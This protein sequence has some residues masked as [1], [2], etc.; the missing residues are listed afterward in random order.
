MKHLF[1]FFAAI[2]LSNFLWAQKIDTT[3]S[4]QIGVSVYTTCDTQPQYPGGLDSLF[5]LIGTNLAYPSDAREFNIQGTVYIGFIVE[6]DGTVSN[7][8]IYKGIGAGC[9]EES[10]RVLSKMK[11]WEPGY[12]NGEAVYTVCYIPI[13]FVLQGSSFRGSKK[14][15]SKNK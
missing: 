14:K 5:K 4:Q 3:L 8:F 10:M 6:P 2:I 11:K 1:L 13:R 12:L 15:K 7:M 9:D